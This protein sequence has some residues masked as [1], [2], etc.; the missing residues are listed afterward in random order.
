MVVPFDRGDVDDPAFLIIHKDET[1]ISL[2]RK[3]DKLEKG[4]YRIVIIVTP[5]VD[6]SANMKDEFVSAEFSII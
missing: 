3:Y 1:S 5:D 6:K 2:D 4:K